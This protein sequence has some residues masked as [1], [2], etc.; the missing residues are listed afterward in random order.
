MFKKKTRE[1][2]KPSE[3]R[4]VA[5]YCSISNGPWPRASLPHPPMSL[6]QNSARS[7]SSQRDS[8][9]PETSQVVAACY[10]WESHTYL[11]Y[12]LPHLPV[13]YLAYWHAALTTAPSYALLHL[14]IHWMHIPDPCSWAF[15]SDLVLKGR[16]EAEG[17]WQANC[18]RREWLWEPDLGVRCVGVG[19]KR[20]RGGWAGI[21]R[22]SRS[23]L[24]W[25]GL[26]TKST[27]TSS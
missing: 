4:L 18:N 21:A 16:S 24:G 25:C 5:P 1:S 20:V 7:R 6:D 9:L 11:G 3:N 10:I 27:T 19:F 17:G 15:G 8:F 12:Y 13:G 14:H 23:Q 26:K 2:F 22:P